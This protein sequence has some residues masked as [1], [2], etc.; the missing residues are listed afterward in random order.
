[1]KISTLIIS[2]VLVTALVTSF[3]VYYASLATQYQDNLPLSVNTT[4]AG[5]NRFDEIRANTQQINQ[6]LFGT[7]TGESGISDLV[8]KFLGSGFNTLKIAKQSFGAFYDIIQNAVTTI[9]GLD[10]V[11]ADV[12]IT[13]A[14]IIIIFI[15]ISV[16]VG[17]D[18]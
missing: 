4:L 8:G 12:F 9:P 18:V 2:M 14:M 15:I 3:G 17:R 5:Y 10:G 1:M 13:I 6:T 16:L 7:P 11:Y